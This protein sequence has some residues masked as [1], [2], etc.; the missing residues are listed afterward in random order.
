MSHKWKI[1]YY[2][3]GQVVSVTIEAPTAADALTMFKASRGVNRGSSGPMVGDVYE[4]TF[5][6]EDEPFVTVASP[7]QTR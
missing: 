7:T 2:G 3:E 4:M 1:S 6:K 5:V